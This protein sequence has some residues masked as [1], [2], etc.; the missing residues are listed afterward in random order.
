MV[1][2]LGTEA[3]ELPEEESERLTILRTIE[4]CLGNG[5]DVNGRDDGGETALVYVKTLLRRG[6]FQL[7]C[8]TAKLLLD[9]GADVDMEDDG[10]Q[11]L[12]SHSLASLDQACDLTRLLLNYGASVWH[13]SDSDHYRGE[14]PFGSF[15]QAIIRC[16]CVDGALVTTALLGRIMGSRPE[17]MRSLVLR[18]MVSHGR[19]IRVMGPVFLRLK[20]LLSPY[21][22]QPQRLRYHAWRTI[23]K[24]IA[25]SNLVRELQQLGLPPALTRFISLDD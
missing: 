25:P 20:S 2:V 21:W 9:S 5:T 23:R 15:L 1:F 8:E 16:R 24:S 3:A 4:D 13:A 10:H 22:R 12:L 11:T 17:A 14:S 7:A 6:Y 18:S 19:H